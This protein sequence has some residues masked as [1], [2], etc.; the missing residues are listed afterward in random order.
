MLKMPV[1]IVMHCES[2][3]HLLTAMFV[4]RFKK[5]GASA[6]LTQTILARLDAR[7]SWGDLTSKIAEE[8]SISSN[9]V[10]VVFLDE[11]EGNFALKNKQD[12]QSFY[13]VFDPS[14]G[15]IKFVVQDLQTPDC[16]S[17]SNSLSTYNS[18]LLQLAPKTISSTWSASSNLSDLSKAGKRL[19]VRL[20]KIA[21]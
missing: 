9:N 6:K 12:L 21:Q 1:K 3:T 19:A 5:P 10:G 17:A 11:V 18:S 8:F 7:P 2:T 14:S 20:I 15:K 16:E 4:V 13:H